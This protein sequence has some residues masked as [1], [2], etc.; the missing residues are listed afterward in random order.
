MGEL[1]FNF[2]FI[3]MASFAQSTCPVAPP[4]SFL[5]LQFLRDTYVHKMVLGYQ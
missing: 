3:Q 1:I 4:V 2:S 5:P